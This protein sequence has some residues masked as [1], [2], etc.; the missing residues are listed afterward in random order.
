MPITGICCPRCRATAIEKAHRGLWG[1][2]ITLTTG[3]Q[4]WLCTACRAKFVAIPRQITARLHDSN[5]ILIH[6][7]VLDGEPPPVLTITPQPEDSFVGHGLLAGQPVTFSLAEA[8]DEQATY[9][10]REIMQ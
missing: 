6:S 2:F 10:Y 8:T 3:A 9:V 4:W 7:V 5:G 1:K